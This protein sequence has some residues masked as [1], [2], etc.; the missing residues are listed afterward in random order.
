M[1]N[2][3]ISYFSHSG[4]TRSIANSIQKQIGGELF[5][6]EPVQAYPHDYDTVVDI[7]KKEQ[8]ANLRPALKGSITQMADFDTVIL[9][10]PNWWNTMPMPVF[11]FLEATD[12]TCKTILPYCTHGGSR[13]GVSE[14]DIRRLCPGASVQAGLPISDSRISTSQTEIIKWLKMTGL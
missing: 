3:L 8:R 6:I 11:T 7:A 9:G 12:F 4:N 13:M 10:Y 5:E 1:Q 14:A 2:T